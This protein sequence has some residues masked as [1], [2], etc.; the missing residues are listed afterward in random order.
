M[1]KTVISLCFVFLMGWLHAQTAMTETEK[2]TDIAAQ[3]VIKYLN[4]RRVDSAYA[5]MGE[6][7]K[8]ELSLEKWRN[9]YSTQLSSLLPFKTIEFK[10]SRSGINKYRV[11]S[12]TPLQVFVSLDNYGKIHTFLVQRYQEDQRKKEMA[13]TDNPGKAVLDKAVD[14]IVSDYIQML[15]NVGISVAIYYKG[16]DHFY[17]YGETKK[18]NKTLPGKHTLYEIGSIT[19]TFT[20]TLLAKAVL[21]KK[22]KLKDPITAYLPDSVKD[23]KDLQQITIEELANHTSGLPNLP[24][25]FNAS[26]TDQSQPYEHYDEKALFAF[27]KEF[28]ATRKPGS[29]YEYS[30]FA[31]GVLGVILERIYKQPY[32][33]LV[34]NY[35][36]KPLRLSH[37]RITLPDSLAV[38]MAQG[39][40]EKG[41]AV[42][43]WN[44]NSL[45]ACGALKSDAAD[46][47][48][49][50]KKQLPA[51]TTVLSPAFA[52]AHTPTFS[53][54][55]QKVGLGWHYM[56]NSTD[57][58]IQHNGGTYGFRTALC[59][60]KTKGI[61]VVVLTNNA[62]N[63][64]ALGP[65]LMELLSGLN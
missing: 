24:G 29:K 59:I 65:K 38:L 43:A 44:F 26:I 37:T 13:A 34:N 11:E 31:V 41:D 5:Q 17:N 36:D 45:Q 64:D 62:N 18:D 8:K 49:Y 23:N 10:G 20:G 28:T 50:G 21:A 15:K 48:Q 61:V 63:G 12:V 32:E 56:M 14:A 27:L 9:I 58:V 42:P 51:F 2:K 22:I 4:N 53:D 16:K 1:R 54:S 52:L 19:K 33:Q 7:F 60:D 55:L 47:L 46:L 25:N 30:N 3:Q 39:Y 6:A 57:K 40:N 35:I